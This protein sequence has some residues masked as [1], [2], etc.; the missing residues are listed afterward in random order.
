MEIISN[1]SS[2]TKEVGNILAKEILKCLEK[3]NSALILSLK[4]DLGAGKT[5]FIQGFALGLG[6]KQKILSPTFIIMNRYDVKSKCFNNFY[7]ID[8]YRIEDYKELEVLEFKEIISDPKNIIAIE[9][10]E[11][12]KNDLFKSTVDIKFKTL[13]E[14]KRKIIIN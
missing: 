7:H 13:E 9:W 11:K 6:I 8:C 4:G 5:T 3:R 2:K 12:I 14:Y 1:N 10:P